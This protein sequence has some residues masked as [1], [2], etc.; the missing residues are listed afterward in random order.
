MDSGG[1]QGLGNSNPALA[2]FG[3][4]SFRYNSFRLF[5]AARNYRNLDNTCSLT[6]RN[7]RQ[8]LR[9]LSG[10]LHV[11]LHRITIKNHEERK[12]VG[13]RALSTLQRRKASFSAAVEWE[14][15]VS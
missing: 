10:L 8:T 13:S 7:A 15:L 11:G 5:R 9:C 3:N 6:P 2:L 1:G 4:R 12:S 14:F